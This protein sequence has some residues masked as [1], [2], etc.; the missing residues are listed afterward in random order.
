MQKGSSTRG[1][2]SEI[3]AILGRHMNNIWTEKKMMKIEAQIDLEAAP[4]RK[5]SHKVEIDSE[6]IGK[7]SKIEKIKKPRE[8]RQNSGFIDFSTSNMHFRSADAAN[9]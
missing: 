5:S 8:T 1:I 6:T 7:S 3:L 9:H 2:V 4:G